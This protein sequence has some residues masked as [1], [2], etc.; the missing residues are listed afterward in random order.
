MKFRQT[1]FTLIELVMVIVLIGVLAAVAVPKFVDLGSDA[2]QAAVDGVAGGLAS[3]AA[4]NYAGR[5]ANAANGSA[6]DNCS[7]VADL[8]QG[9]LPTDYRI[10]DAGIKPDLSTTC[11]VSE[12][13][14]AKAPFAATGIN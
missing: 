13:K 4:V 14:G 11:Y 5:K 8:L 7:K 10:E 1:G 6:L 2:R 12:P 3:A 9:G